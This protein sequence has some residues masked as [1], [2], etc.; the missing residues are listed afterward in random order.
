[1][2]TRE[3]SPF[4]FDSTGVKAGTFY[5]Q[6]S[7]IGRLHAFRVIVWDESYERFPLDKFL[8][9][10][11]W[12]LLPR[13]QVDVIAD[14]SVNDWIVRLIHV[15]V[16]VRSHCSA[17]WSVG[18]WLIISQCFERQCF[19]PLKWILDTYFIVQIVVPSNARG[20]RD[21]CYSFTLKCRILKI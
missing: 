12:L 11:V 1:M 16:H 3:I 9:P 15:Y 21:K 20:K 18:A 8:R 10:T 14:N 13:T 6:P 17:K 4:V 19:L 5:R 7:I 2:W